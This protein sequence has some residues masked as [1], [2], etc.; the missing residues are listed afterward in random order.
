MEGW[1]GGWMAELIDDRQDREMI[2]RQIGRQR[3]TNKLLYREFQIIYE[4]T[5]SQ[6]GGASFILMFCCQMY[7]HLVF[8]FLLRE[9]TPLS[10]MNCLSFNKLLCSEVYITSNQLSFRTIKIGKKM[11]FIIFIPFLRFLISLYGSK[12]LTH[13][14]FILPEQFPLISLIEQVC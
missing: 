7:L 14:I 1:M 10:F 9:L 3:R 11:K 12:V 4:Y 8:L 2:G 5:A 13:S 6:G